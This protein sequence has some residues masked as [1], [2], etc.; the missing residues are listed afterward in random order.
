MLSGLQSLW[1]CVELCKTLI[2]R[3]ALG[4]TK[5]V[6][7]NFV[8]PDGQSD[9]FYECLTKNVRVPD[10]MSERK[11]KNIHVVDEKKR[12]TSDHKGQQL[13]FNVIFAVFV[14]TQSTLNLR[15]STFFPLND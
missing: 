2:H 3:V 14:G 12:N 4:S 11:Y 8:G 5:S 10:Q 9:I 6:L 1:R 15:W 13:D 7:S